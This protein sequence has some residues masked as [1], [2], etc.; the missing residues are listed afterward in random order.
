MVIEVWLMFGW[1]LAT[2]RRAGDDFHVKKWDL[3]EV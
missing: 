3:S 2:A 1:M